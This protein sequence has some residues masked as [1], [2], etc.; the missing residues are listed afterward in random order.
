MTQRVFV[1]NVNE[2]NFNNYDT[3]EQ[4]EGKTIHYVMGNNEQPIKLSMKTDHSAYEKLNEP[5]VYD[6]Q[7]KIHATSKGADLK[8][9]DA[10]FIKKVDLD[11][12]LN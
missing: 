4:V 7:F 8:I 2:Y 6:I 1:L 11:G 12:L 10:K 5:G 9:K 3:G